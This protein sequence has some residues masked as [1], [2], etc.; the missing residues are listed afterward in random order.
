MNISKPWPTWVC[1]ICNLITALSLVLP[2]QVTALS[3][4]DF[5]SGNQSMPTKLFPN[6]VQ[7]PQL[8]Y[9]PFTWES[10]SQSMSQHPVVSFFPFNK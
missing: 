6:P 5:P 10:P 4:K 2:R 9:L 1:M 7:P 3:H 8:I